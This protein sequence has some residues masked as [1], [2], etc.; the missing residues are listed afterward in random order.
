MY[1]IVR[2]YLSLSLSL[3][4][5]L[6]ILSGRKVAID[7]KRTR[8][9]T[10]AYVSIRVQ[11]PRMLSGSKGAATIVIAYVYIRQHIRIHT[12]KYVVS[13]YVYIRQHTY[14]A[15]AHTERVQ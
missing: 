9:Y 11:L 14:T 12:Y 4:L 10:S 13:T 5:S 1:T 7:S 8:I 2:A 6:R 3:S 15:S